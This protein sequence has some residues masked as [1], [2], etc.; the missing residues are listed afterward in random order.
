MQH[1]RSSVSSPIAK[2]FFE[3]TS[4]KPK[5]KCQPV[6]KL[7][8]SVQWR[9]NTR[10]HAIRTQ[11]IYYFSK[12]AVHTYSYTVWQIQL[13]IKSHWFQSERGRCMWVGERV[14]AWEKGREREAEWREVIKEKIRETENT[15]ADFT[16]KRKRALCAGFLPVTSTQCNLSFE[17]LHC[18]LQRGLEFPLSSTTLS[19]LFLSLPHALQPCTVA[20]ILRLT[21]AFSRLIDE[22][23]ETA[24]S[25]KL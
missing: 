7:T 15:R 23:S 4:T 5:F 25:C 10:W 24:Y 9:R 16:W 13:I 2:N 11:C 17:Q 12:L 8:E 18:W 6:N 3:C 21:C 19:A 22:I 14:C 20:V 1:T